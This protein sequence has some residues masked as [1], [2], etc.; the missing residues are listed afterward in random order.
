[1][2]GEGGG[3]GGETQRESMVGVL[4]ST[5]CMIYAGRGG[6]MSNESKRSAVSVENVA[7]E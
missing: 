1:M 7:S 5:V 4:V 6:G 3:R 2:Q